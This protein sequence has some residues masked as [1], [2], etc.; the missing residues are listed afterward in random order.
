MEFACQ[1]VRKLF[2]P[3]LVSCRSPE[4][5]IKLLQERVKREETKKQGQ[6]VLNRLQLR[7]Q[8]LTRLTGEHIRLKS[9]LEEEI[10]DQTV[11]QYLLIEYTLF[12]V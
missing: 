9:Q 11:N 4:L 3:S 10:K 5:D 12:L 1:S 8:D 2:Q 6:M 7:E